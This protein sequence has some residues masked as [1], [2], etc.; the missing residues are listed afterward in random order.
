ML[1]STSIDCAQRCLDFTL[2][3]C[4]SSGAVV[5]VAVTMYATGERRVD[6]VDTGDPSAVVVDEDESCESA[7][8]SE[9]SEMEQSRM[10]KN[11]HAPRS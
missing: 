5:L 8:K 4:R 2:S 1:R 9:V 11:M 7:K 3:P 10:D 6:V